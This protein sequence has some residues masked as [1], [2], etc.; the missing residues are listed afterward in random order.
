MQPKSFGF[1]LMLIIATETCSA[2]S[3]CSYSLFSPD[4]LAGSALAYPGAQSTYPFGIND[5]G[6]I[7]GWYALNTGNHGF[8]Y[9]GGSFTSVDYPGALSTYANGINNSGQIVG[10]Y[11]DAQGRVHG[12]LKTGANF[13]PIDYPGATVTYAA[14][15]NS[16]GQIAG[17]YQDAGNNYHAFL[18]S[19]GSFTSIDYPGATQ[20]YAQG[21]NDNGQ[22]VGYYSGASG[23]GHG[24]L[25]SAGSFTSL[26]FPGAK[27]TIA[28]AINN[29]GQ[30]V[31]YYGDASG[32]Q[33][34]FL[35]VN[36][37]FASFDYPGGT[38]T[39]A[40]G[41]N[42]NSQIV[43]TSL[44]SGSRL[45][46][47]TA[48]S[49]PAVNAPTLGVP[50]GIADVLTGSGC[51]WT[52]TSNVGWITITSGASGTGGGQV[53][54]SVTPNTSGATR[55]GTLTIAG[56]T[57]TITQGVNP[58]ITEYSGGGYG[59]TTGPDS[60]IWVSG[61]TA[62]T[63]GYFSYYYG[64]LA[65]DNISGAASLWIAPGPDGALWF[66]EPAANN[67]GRVSAN[68]YNQITTY[69]APTA[70]AGLAEIV[71]GP[72]GALWFTESAA[73]KIGRVTTTGAFSEFPIPTA[74]S[75]PWGITAGPDGAVWFT[76]Q[77]ANKIGRVT[78]A[79]AFSEYPIPTAGSFPFG[80]TA[81]P[82]GALWF[83][84]QSA[85]KIGR[86][87]TAGAV[88]EFPT[89]TAGSAPSGITTGP[90]GALWFTEY[91]ANQIGRITTGGAIAEYPV[92]TPKAG[93]IG[94]TTGPDSAVWFT[95]YTAGKIARVVLPTSPV[96]IES[97][98]S[99]LSV[100]VDGTTYTTPKS[101]N[102][103]E[104][105]QHTISALP[106]PPSSGTRYVFTNWSDGGAQTHT[107]TAV[108]G[109]VYTTTGFTAQYLIT[110]AV[111]GSGSITFNP[112]SPDGYYTSGTTVYVNA[113][114]AAGYQFLGWGGD[115]VNGKYG[116]SVGI[117]QGS[118][119]IA[120]FAAIPAATA[121][122]H[123]VPVTPCRVADTRVGNGFTGSFGP[124]VM[125]GGTSRDFPVPSSACG[126]PAN[127]QAYSLNITV[128]PRGPL[129]WLTTWPTGQ[130]KPG[131]VSTLNSFDGRVVANAA[132]VPAGTNGA[133]SVFVSDTTDV[134]VDINGY[135]TTFVPPLGAGLAFYPVAPC[136]VA[137][138]RGYGFTGS[139]GPPS[140]GGGSTRSFP[141]SQGSCGIP[142]TAQAYLLNMT[143]APP[144]PL[145]YLTVWPAGQSQP[146][147]STLN[148]YTGAVV[149]NAA[150]VPAGTN[151]A[152]SVYASNATDLIIDINGY[153]AAP[154]GSGALS[155]YPAPP[156]R[157]ADT[158]AANGF[159]GALGPPGMTGGATR[160]FP[161]TWSP[162]A[163]P[164]TAQA[165]SL[166][167]TV[168]PPGPLGWLSAWGGSAQTSISTL[169]SFDGRVVANAAIIPAAYVAQA[170][171][172]INVYVSDA[173]DVIIDANGYFAP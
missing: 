149:A 161:V 145:A 2:A 96:T 121:A 66:T 166:N 168:V 133:I 130:T 69:P 115:V 92:P 165:Y 102:W 129:I 99:G 58:A 132:L 24:F 98:P 104:G 148:S 131:N 82:D 87:T 4:L 6:Q 159:I 1:A 76:E 71:A 155:F 51:A 124:P 67:I 100:A 21:I 125:A 142:S 90:D 147:V 118:T 117:G 30:V 55:T 154:G 95:E 50:A 18:Y 135:F 17:Y 153:F 42:D 35:N 86:I 48:S 105:S 85:G 23:N 28:S 75:S 10:Y 78:T 114:A 89:P 70:N 151:G 65:L 169:N 60:E 46:F 123:F 25:D 59:I 74:N 57:F 107:I 144:G 101:F 38:Q 139:S 167:F 163:I 36:G 171:S 73:N 16:V 27:G 152:V 43:G 39:S 29:N 49:A 32:N 128:V 120:Y 14:G 22:I 140:L 134:I 34:G 20:T 94:I 15:I 62:S 64:I 3:A 83:T 45:A 79:G 172:S 33:H 61:T 119:A 47:L 11:A 80:I 26:D 52:A 88:S 158:R 91:S 138:T 93:P 103:T 56:Q 19:V 31:G 143:V 68:G 150:I 162:C 160:L 106:P 173:T 77:S 109:G 122:L 37:S 72:D 13:I 12:F 54:Y 136:R 53:T 156:C 108:P 41:I 127:A 164:S 84:E 126:I 170:Y 157:V 141:I 113:V 7:V 63:I 116:Y 137:D 9:S 8:L 44:V 97:E 112:T 146:V 81:G 40:Y 111:S 110:A 5:G